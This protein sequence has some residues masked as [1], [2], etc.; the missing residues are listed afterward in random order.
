MVSLSSKRQGLSIRAI[1]HLVDS[2]G[3]SNSRYLAVP[4]SRPVYGRRALAVGKLDPVK[5]FLKE[6][7]Q[8]GRGTQRWRCC[9]SFASVRLWT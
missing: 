8:A 4:E 3:K 2:G 9:G 5:E 6:G 1:K 7:L